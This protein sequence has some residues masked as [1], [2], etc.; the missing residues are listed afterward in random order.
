MSK[1][2]S[3]EDYKLSIV[4]FTEEGAEATCEALNNGSLVL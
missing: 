4:W 3:D 2:I 1:L